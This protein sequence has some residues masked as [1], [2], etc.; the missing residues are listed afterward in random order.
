MWTTPTTPAQIRYFSKHAPKRRVYGL[1]MLVFQTLH[2]FLAFPGWKSIFSWAFALLPD[3]QFL[4]PYLAGTAL[5]AMHALFT[6]TWK[7]YW[8]DR[9]DDDPNT[10]SK[11]WMSVVI[12]AMLLV[13]EI[14]GASMFFKGLVKP[15]EEKNIALVEENHRDASAALQQEYKATKAEIVALFEER[16]KATTLPFE[17][18]I[19]ALQ[20]RRVDSEATR[21]YIAAQIAGIKRQRDQ[22]LEPVARDKAAKLAAALDDYN[23]RS[24]SIYTTSETQ[25]GTLLTH[26]ADEQ[27][28]YQTERRN[29]G[30]LAWIISVLLISLIAGLGYV[31]VRINVKSGIL[32]IRNFTAL[33][34]HGSVLERLGTAFGDAFNR[35]TLQV[36]VYF[37]RL[38]S[39]KDPLE[40]FDGTVVAK[41]SN[42]NTPALPQPAKTG[43]AKLTGSDALDAHGKVMSKVR[44]VRE[45]YDMPDYFPS[46]EVYQYE[47]RRAIQ[48]NGTYAGADWSDTLGK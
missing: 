10:D 17:N 16:A 46:D 3:F 20:R 44:R 8:Y 27:A 19:Q 36:A 2:G 24:R 18:K 37:H 22:A 48:M 34:A 25:R 6:V 40:S 23:A 35:R 28:R 47:L 1:L 14:Y 30:S 29:A 15:P 5:F 11:I 45:E 31:I 7:T 42:Y 39:P 4:A 26:N 32:P 12:G 38:L 43:V 13:T 33:D 41:P 21:K 9:L